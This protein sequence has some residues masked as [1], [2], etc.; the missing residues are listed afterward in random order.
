M[1]WAIERRETA[2]PQADGESS[3]LSADAV[4]AGIIT[5]ADEKLGATITK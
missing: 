4:R 2:R 3:I 1:P 5:A